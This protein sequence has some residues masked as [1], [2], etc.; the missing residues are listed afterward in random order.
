MKLRN[1]FVSNSSSSS[2]IIA[3]KDSSK[4]KTKIEIEVDLS[5]FLDE[6]EISTEHELLKKYI[7][8]F[9]Y[10]LEELKDNKDYLKA[11]EEI[12]K[13]NK[14]FFLSCS[15]DSGDSSES[16]FCEN[17]LENIKSK[18]ITIIQGEGGY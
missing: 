1:G 16:Y 9:L 10:S 12:K 13:G 17:G 15:S 8:D 11:L 6:Y 5:D 18:D 2:F 4:L 3:A 14:I 7:D